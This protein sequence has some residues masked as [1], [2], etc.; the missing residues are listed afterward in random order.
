MAQLEVQADGRVAT[1]TVNRPEA[2]NAMSGELLR[3]IIEE[4][5]RLADRD[6][7]GCIILTGA[8]EKSFIV[9]ADIK[10]MKDKNAAGGRAWAELGQQVTLAIEAVPQPVIAAVNGYALGG[11]CE[12]AMACD[13][14]LA[15]EN[16]RFGQP[17]INLG[18][19][20]GW[21]A[22][23]RLVR[24]CG[25]GIARELVYTGRMIDAEEALRWG[26]VNA[27]YPAGE[28][29]P[30]AKEMAE[31]IASKSWVVQGYAKTAMKRALDQD[32]AGGLALEANLFGLCFATEDQ[33]EGM[34]AFV[35][36]RQA[37]FKHR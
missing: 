15:S 26:L 28:L 31:T 27:V 23:Q 25:S 13:L 6:D 8:G 3:T 35:D 36:K 12:I 37:D 29:L 11:G 5:G 24:L 30:K 19:I 20:P 33:K 4:F 17:E 18:V 7:V 2:L 10:E 9:G 14:R 16:A 21:S 1:V 32:L 22:T 34:A